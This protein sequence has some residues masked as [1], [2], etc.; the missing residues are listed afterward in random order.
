MSESKETYKEFIFHGFNIN[1][2]K[3][4][5]VFH[6]S[7]DDKIYFNPEIKIDLSKVKNTSKIASAVF[8]LGMAELPSFYKA[9]CSP[10]ITIK[11][12]YLDK[13]QIK[14]W[15]N[16]YEK[17]LGEFFYKNKIDFRNLINIKIDP[18]APHL[19]IGG[20]RM[21]PKR[22]SVLLPIGGGKDSIVSAEILR[23][24]GFDFTW[25]AIEPNKATK[26]VIKTS[27]NNKKIFLGRDV[28]KNFKEITNL[29]KKGAYNGHVPISSVY[30]FSATLVAQIYGFKYI[31][32]SN[33][34]SANTGNLKYLGVEI[35]HQYSKSF[36]FEKQIHEY[37]QK[38]ISPDINYFSLLRN[39][40]DIQIMKKFVEYPQYFNSFIS[41]NPGLKTGKWCGKCAK[42]GFVFAGLNAF[43]DSKTT[44]Q[45]F[46]KNLFKDKSLLPLYRELV[47]QKD[48]KPFDCVGTIEETLLALHLAKQKYKKL[49]SILQKINT[50]K[51]SNYSKILTS[52]T[53]EHLVPNKF[54]KEKIAIA[55]FGTEGKALYEYFKKRPNTEIHIFDED[56]LREGF[57]SN[58]NFHNNLII[59]ADFKIVYKSPGIPTIKLKIKSKNTKISSLTN[60]FMENIKGSVIGITG[61]K[62]KSTISS[63]INHILKG[64]YLIGNIG[65]T[66]LN[67]LE[68][69]N[70][71][72]EN[73]Y[74]YEMSSFQCEHLE[75]SPQIAVLTNIFH[76][77]LNHHENFNEYKDAKFN[78]TNFQNKNNLFINT[79]DH[80]YKTKAQILKFKKSPIKFKTELKGEHNQ[81]NCFIA[82]TVARQFGLSDKKIKDSIKT[83]KPLPLRLEKVMEKKG[84]IFYDDSLATIPEATIESI[85]SLKNVNTII[86]GGLNR[87]IPLDNFAKYLTKTEIKNFIIFPETGKEMVKYVKNRNIF[88][89]NNM[90]NAVS[91]AY[92]NGKG[93]CLLSNAA[94]S[95]NLFKNYKDK[96]DQYRYWINKLG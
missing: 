77:H 71:K 69:K 33:E 22:E 1:K 96:S 5:I 49:P 15:E 58:I 92:E 37:I 81:L 43:I 32:L 25:F 28:Q 90:K 16:L 75:K 11:A 13:V 67:F 23:E 38:Y 88:E 82:Y 56:H 80:N 6:Y 91:K 19:K 29:N 83:F 94:A 70:N 41:C 27:K 85:K 79:S 60:L 76:D 95:F 68:N 84:V 53:T 63:L 59:P 72:K 48:N 20:H 55:G 42:C 9:Y 35:N 86:L 12:G 66:G 50:D 62:G 7:F 30:A 31:I 74:I 44:E 51:A 61:T 45:I 26:Q 3:N 10:K 4:R 89:V 54:L 87:N 34:R 57:P 14:F 18:K 2:K 36:E 52:E 8:N 78:I 17:G 73:V 65:T 46:G 40:Y 64:S 93:I 21:S 39:L 47:G 24:K